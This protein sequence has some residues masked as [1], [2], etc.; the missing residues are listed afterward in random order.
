MILPASMATEILEH[1]RA[2]LPNEACG[3]L[4]GDASGIRRLYCVANADAS[5]VSYTIDPAGHFA[6]LQD[7]EQNGWELIGAFHSHVDGPAYPSPTDVAGAA[8]PE[9]TWLVVGPITGAPQIRA[10]RIEADVIIEEKLE[11]IQG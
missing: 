4:A 6:A 11:I 1:S 5:A 2:A 7:A 3:L 10:Y 8:E 9:W